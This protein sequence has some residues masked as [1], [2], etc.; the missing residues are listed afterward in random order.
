MQAT[1]SKIVELRGKLP[2]VFKLVCSSCKRARKV[3]REDFLDLVV[4]IGDP[5]KALKQFNCGHCNDGIEYEYETPAKGTLL[6]VLNNFLSMP[7]II[8]RCDGKVMIRD[9]RSSIEKGRVHVNDVVETSPERQVKSGDYIQY[10]MKRYRH[11]FIV[12]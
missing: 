7:Q 8:H 2:Q 9:G 10:G 3:S 11:H 12:P 5:Q 6:F 1:D 4:K